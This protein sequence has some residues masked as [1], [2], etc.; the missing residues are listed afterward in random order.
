MNPSFGESNLRSHGYR[1]R[2]YARCN[3]KLS[4]KRLVEE[5]TS[6]KS[7]PVSTSKESEEVVESS[8]A[9]LFDYNSDSA[10]DALSVCSS[11]VSTVSSTLSAASNSGL[12]KR[13]RRKRPRYKRPHLYNIGHRGAKAY[14]MDNSLESF[15]KAISMNVHVI[16]LDVQLTKDEKIVVFH[17]IYVKTSQTETERV[18]S[19]TLEEMQRLR[20][21]VQTFETVLDH[22]ALVARQCKNNDLQV[23]IDIKGEGVIVPMYMTIKNFCLI[24]HEW[25]AERFFVATFDHM[26][27]AEFNEF[28]AYDRNRLEGIRKVLLLGGIPY[29]YCQSFTPLDPDYVCVDKGVMIGKNAQSFVGDAHERGIGVF[30]YTVNEKKMMETCL[31]LGVDGLCS[32]YPD[33]VSDVIDASALEG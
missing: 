24:N 7:L 25:N 28:L 10:S 1:A 19:V 32:D 4:T 33:R 13:L 30:V 16:E 20:P 31:D 9:Y 2:P 15:T 11:S 22:I 29:G 26:Q 14:A 3:T 21:E 18:S 8:D 23:Y 17:D 5:E 12:N 27:M 6:V